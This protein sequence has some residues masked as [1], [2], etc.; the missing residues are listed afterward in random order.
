M[1][2]QCLVPGLRAQWSPDQFDDLADTLDHNTAD[3]SG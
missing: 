2:H 3:Q 1:D